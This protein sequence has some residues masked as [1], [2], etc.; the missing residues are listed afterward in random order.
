M[1]NETNATSD[2][3]IQELGR[4]SFT[5]DGTTLTLISVESS[6]KAPQPWNVEQGTAA[7][8]ESF[9][10]GIDEESGDTVTIARIGSQAGQAIPINADRGGRLAAWLR[11]RCM[12]TTGRAMGANTVREAMLQ[13]EALAIAGRRY[14]V[15][16]RAYKIGSQLIID[17]GP[18]RNDR[19]IPEQD[20]A[21]YAVIEAGG[22]RIVDTLQDGI[23]F[24]RGPQFA[25]FPP[26][27][28][29]GDWH[30]LLPLFRHLPVRTEYVPLLIAYAAAIWFLSDAQI[31]L[32]LITGRPGQGKSFT[33]DTLAWLTDPTA[34][35]DSDKEISPGISMPKT[36]D[37][38]IVA[39]RDSLVLYVDNMSRANQTMSDAITALATGRTQKKRTLYTDSQA[40]S[41]AMQHPAIF[42]G[43][44][45][46]GLEADV[47]RRTIHIDASD[48]MPPD[49]LRDGETMGEWRTRHLPAA[50]AGLMDLIAK[51]M[52]VLPDIA[53]NR[54]QFIDWRRWLRACDMVMGESSY[55]MYERLLQG[56]VSDA[57][58]SNPVDA[59]MLACQDQFSEERTLTIS[60]IITTVMPRMAL[61]E[62]DRPCPK[63]PREFGKQ[64]TMIASS[65]QSRGWTVRQNP[66]SSRQ[67]TWTIQAP[68]IPSGEQPA[69]VD[70]FAGFGIPE[71]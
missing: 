62:S 59:V 16:R 20:P 71:A 41:I 34:N 42:N 12:A 36:V 48:P 44:D 43:V 69:T 18:E 39:A 46:T 45:P 49:D 27:P 29:D 38:L 9:R 25:S 51:A 21:R 52:R 26:I 30:D 63:D 67:R 11:R 17:L 58:L 70:P 28:V 1:R 23:A 22:Y 55:A 31:P 33:C 60:E 10:L 15:C 13:C 7:V 66:R 8:F 64:L 32:L 35:G 65:L 54:G 6:Q 2:E 5:G 50:I 47:A 14:R 19:R 37:D 68:S 61:V 4:R 24:Y 56:D 40:T 57:A 53:E 3:G